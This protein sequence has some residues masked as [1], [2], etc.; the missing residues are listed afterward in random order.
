MESKSSVFSG[1]CIEADWQLGCGR[2]LWTIIA[3][4][5]GSGCCDHGDQAEAGIERGSQAE[6]L[7]DYRVST[8]HSQ[9]TQLMF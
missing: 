7:F 8:P 6:Y 2:G 9:T 4:Y 5:L 1:L 3:E